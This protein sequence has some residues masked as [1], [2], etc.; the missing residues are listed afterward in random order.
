MRAKLRFPAAD[1]YDIYY[2]EKRRL[3]R[4]LMGGIATRQY[5]EKS[6][7]LIFQGFSG[8]KKR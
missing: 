2:G 3:N 6:T 5:I 4:N 1:I 8:T 7:S